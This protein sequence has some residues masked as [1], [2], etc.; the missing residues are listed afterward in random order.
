[1]LLSSYFPK[2]SFLV[3]VCWLPRLVDGKEE[4]FQN[5][6]VSGCLRDRLGD[7]NYTIRVCNS[8]DTDE[9]YCRNPRISYDPEIRL[10]L[11]NW[12]TVYYE[13]WIIQIILSEL[14]DVPT[15]IDSGI[16]NNFYKLNVTKSI[17]YDQEVDYYASLERAF[18]SNGCTTV[19]MASSSRDPKEHERCGHFVTE[20]WNARKEKVQN[21]V[22]SGI[23]ESPQGLGSVGQEAWYIPKSTAEKDPTLI[24]YWGIAGEENRRKL[25]E[26]F[27]RPTTWKNYCD[28]VSTDQCQTPDSVAQRAPMEDE[29]GRYFFQDMYTGYFRNTEKNDCDNNP[30]CTGHFGDYP[31]TCLCK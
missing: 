24:G 9:R 2:V 30:N 11:Q 21:L 25:A 18:T 8:E 1:M 28:L 27:K 29:Y 16:P 4:F 19:S 3:L 22:R 12:E 10:I 20:S 5:P 15:S 31:C 17:E 26:R 14:L 6:F 23:I 7:E 13:N